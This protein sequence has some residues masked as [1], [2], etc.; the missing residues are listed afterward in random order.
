LGDRRGRHAAGV[1]STTSSASS[2]STGS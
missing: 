2:I 1:S